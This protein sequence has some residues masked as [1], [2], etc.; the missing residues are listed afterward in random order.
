MQALLK[1]GFAPPTRYLEATIKKRRL[2]G[3]KVPSHWGHSLEEYVKQAIA[4]KEKEL[5]LHNR[6]LNGRFSTPMTQGY[7]PELDYSPFLMDHA[8]NYY[9]ELIGIL[10][11]IVELGRLVIMVDVS[12]LSSHS[13]QPR[14]GHLDQVFHIFGYI[15]RNKRATLVFDKSRVNW[16]ESAFEKHDWTDFYRDAEEKIPPNAPSLLVTQFR[17]IVL[18][19]LITRGIGLQDNLKQEFLFSSIALQ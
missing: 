7:R 8:E 11:W 2:T 1:D 5:L 3:D 16:D 9:I 13:L 18:L 19:M 17:L 10:H 6:R 4:N 12:L 15:K 14:Q